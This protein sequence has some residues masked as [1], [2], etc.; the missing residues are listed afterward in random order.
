MSSVSLWGEE[1]SIQEDK[2]ILKKTKSATKKT[3]VSIEKQLKSKKLSIEDRLALITENVYK[4]LGHYKDNTRVIRNYDDFVKYIDVCIQDGVIAI[5]TETDNSLDAI[6]CKIMGLCLYSPSNKQ[7]YFPVNHINRETGELLENQITE[8]QIREQLQRVK[9]SGITTVFHNGKFDYKVLKMTCGVEV[10]VNWDTMIGCRMIDENEKSASL[11]NQY[12]SKIDKSQEKYSIEHLFEGVQYSIVDP[13]VFALYAATDSYMTY[14]LYLYQKNILE[15]VALSKVLKLFKRVE[16]PL[17]IITA[18]MELTGVKIDVEYAKRLLVKYSKLVDDWNK[19][20][21][22][23]MLKYKDKIDTWR[24]SKEANYKPKKVNKKGEVV[25]GKS[26]N[27]QLDEKINFD[28]STQLSILLYDILGIQPTSS[29]EGSTDKDAL[30]EIASRDKLELCSMILKSREINTLY[31][32]FIVK[33]PNMINPK[34]GKIHCNFNQLGKEERGVVT[35]RFSSSDPNL[36]Q[37]PSHNKE[38]RLMFEA[39]EGK[40]LVSSDYSAQEVRLTA[41]YS[42]DENMLNAYKQNKDLYS[43]IAALSFNRKYEDC[44]ECYPEGTELVIDGQKIVCGYKTHINEV[45]KKYRGMAKSIVLGLIYGRGIYSI[46]E[47]IGKSK[48]EAQEVVDKFFNTFPTAKR[49][50]DSTQN[51]ARKLEYVEDFYGRR[52]HLPDINL[53]PYEVRYKEE[54]GKKSTTFNPLLECKDRDITQDA[55]IKKYIE[56]CDSKSMKYRKTY[57]EVKKQAEKEGVD[58]IANTDRIAKAERQSVNS[59]VQGGAATLTKLAM[60]DIYNDKILNELGFKM[61]IVV[62]DEILGEC[63]IENAEKVSERLNYVMSH[64]AD[65]Y[66]NVPLTCDGDICSHWYENEYDVHIVNEFN[67]LKMKNKDLTTEEIIG[68]I[69]E[70]HSE[71]LPEKIRSVIE[72]IK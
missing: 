20:L 43:E 4:I 58:I 71:S 12:I 11:K 33:L 21:D 42:Q 55:V 22:D 67:D 44:L 49:W 50:I 36:Q 37:I 31:D 62:H 46:A 51:K 41:H 6:T 57:Y 9:D 15:D 68:I 72:N 25:Y 10:P 64:S 27:E 47:Q 1:F 5:D 17:V 18:E 48:E 8:E 40:I 7:C 38:I 66:L 39:D 23:E 13:D 32:D 16:M 60:I 14:K 19:R 70:N 53:P 26:K 3:N 2:D 52:R 34:T 54:K 29:G 61:L 59:V 63:P 45:G 28:S 24:L 56:K 65:G 30:K 35:G 69:I